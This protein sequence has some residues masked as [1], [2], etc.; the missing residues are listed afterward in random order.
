MKY[1]ILLL[2]PTF[3]LFGAPEVDAYNLVTASGQT[4][5]HQ[6]V[7]R[8]QEYGKPLQ[9][10]HVFQ[11][12]GTGSVILWGPG[13]RSDYGK[14]LTRR[15][16]PIIDDRNPESGAMPNR[17]SKYGS[18]VRAYGSVVPGYGKPLRGR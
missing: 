3:L 7:Y 5:A 18:A 11:S 4:Q 6:H 15:S 16:G 17:G 8:R 9:Q 10:G 13:T 12:H 1:L 14:T 2:A